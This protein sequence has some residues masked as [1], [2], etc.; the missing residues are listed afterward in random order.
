MPAA[1][2]HD[3]L[4]APRP[5]VISTPTQQQVNRAGKIRALQNALDLPQGPA[6]VQVWFDGKLA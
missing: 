3:L 2:A 4:A 1:G 5:P 6:N